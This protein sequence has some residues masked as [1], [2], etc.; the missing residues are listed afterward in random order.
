M[1]YT[2]HRVLSTATDMFSVQ[3]IRASAVNSTY[4]RFNNA[5]AITS[6]NMNVASL[7]RARSIGKITFPALDPFSAVAS[8]AKP[9]DTRIFTRTASRAPSRTVPYFRQERIQHQ[10]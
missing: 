4:S 5:Q 1:R 2:E 8:P 10:N 9:K 6:V 7:A 3:I